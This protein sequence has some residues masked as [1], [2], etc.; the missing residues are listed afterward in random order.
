MICEESSTHLLLLS[1]DIVT[2]SSRVTVQKVEQ[3]L[4]AASEIYSGGREDVFALLLWSQPQSSC[5]P[6]TL[7]SAADAESKPAV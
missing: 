4:P 2:L 1:A 6:D 7:P 5:S 3:L